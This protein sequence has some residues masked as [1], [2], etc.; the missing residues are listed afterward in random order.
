MKEKLGSGTV[1][2]LS[3]LELW[4]LIPSPG[5]DEN[6]HQWGEVGEKTP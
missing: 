2:L 4:D 5:E 3:G 6:G 1:H